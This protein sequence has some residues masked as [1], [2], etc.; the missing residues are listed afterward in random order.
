MVKD[1]EIDKALQLLP[2]N[3]TYYFTK[4][5]IPRALDQSLLQ[6]QAGSFGLIGNAYPSVSTAFAAAKLHAGKDDLIL[7]CGSVFVVAE[8]L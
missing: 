6:Q 1:K 2:K 3:A 8:L 4:A 5:A 7:V